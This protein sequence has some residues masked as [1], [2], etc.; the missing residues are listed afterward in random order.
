MKILII[1]DLLVYGGA[2]LQSRRE[3]QI[4]ENYDNDV[5]LL[6][7]DSNIHNKY[8]SENKHYNINL[9]KNK[10]LKFY[11]KIF[12]D[13]LLY[14]KI[15]SIIKK[16][17]PEVIHVNNLYNATFTQFPALKGFKCIQTIRDFS[18][19]CPKTTCIHNDFKI[20]SGFNSGQCKEKCF[21]NEIV[22]F[23]RI[24]RFKNIMKLRKKFINRFIAP[25]N[26]LTSYCVEHGYEIECLNN[27]FDF[28]KVKFREKLIYNEQKKYLFYG[29]INEIKGFSD[30]IEAFSIFSQNKNVKL[31]VAGK[32][33]NDYEDEF[34][35]YKNY[36]YVEYLGQ[37]TNEKIIDLLQN[38]YCVVVPSKWIENYPNTV[39]ESLATGT[40][41]IGSS[42]GGIPEMINDKELIF[43]VLD[44]DSF[45]KTLEK[46]Y[47][48]D[49]EV[50]NNI[51]L[52]SKKRV[53]KENSYV[54]YYRKLINIM[55][56][57]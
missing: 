42:R 23:F 40:L 13:P 57:L 1:N 12:F 11:R 32:V 29:V 9:T 46:T 54:S 41:V 25:S 28:E 7:F 48:M 45:V 55:N 20:C 43:D 5:Y 52:K 22:H 24:R 17:N 30:L 31:I 49:R 39:L 47:Y 50:Y 27:S 10:I 37:L 33:Q 38:I 36:P 2:E 44:K 53:E 4:L 19:V 51:V 15:R 21:R 6:T 35:K 18:A 34:N 26:V 8:D 56:N 3:K 16:I 14:Y